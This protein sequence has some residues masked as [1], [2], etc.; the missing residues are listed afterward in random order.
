MQ[1]QK[2]NYQLLLDKI[3]EEQ[4][5][6]R[7]RLLLHSCCAPCSS[8]VLEYLGGYFEITLYFDNPNI[9]TE[10]EFLRRA[11]ELKRLVREIH[12]PDLSVV[13]APYDH[14]RF[15][16]AVRGLEEEPERG[17]RCAVCFHQRLQ[18]TAVFAGEYAREHPEKPFDY[19]CTTLTISP[20]K[21]AQLLNR[22]GQQLEA[23]Y[24]LRFLPSDF[25]K[26]GG[27]LRSTELSRE[28]GL[29]RQDYCGCEF[30]RRERENPRRR[31]SR[32]PEEHHAAKSG[33]AG[34]KVLRP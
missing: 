24:R 2:V 7:P 27:Y 4:Q 12:V 33:S 20:L 34:D 17:K 6:T 22:L 13:I 28:Y 1:N 26:R 16:R 18:D 11:E 25:K 8:A 29:Y 5:G 9:E 30:S 31:A 19:F 10:E 3:L 23:Q 21:D 14:Q 32:N 15:L